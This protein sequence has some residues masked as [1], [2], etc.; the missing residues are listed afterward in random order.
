MHLVPVILLLIVAQPLAE[1]GLKT[2]PD[3]SLIPLADGLIPLRA[4]IQPISLDSHQTVRIAVFSPRP[5]PHSKCF[6]IVR[7]EDNWPL[8]LAETVNH[9]RLLN[10]LRRG[11]S[12]PSELS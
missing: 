10:P 5:F 11:R 9:V 4:S 12:P 2:P 1:S 8:W 6:S 3:F 7:A